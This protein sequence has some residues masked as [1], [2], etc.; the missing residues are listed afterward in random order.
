MKGKAM[1]AWAL[2]LGDEGVTGE[3]LQAAVVASLKTNKFMP[4]PA[5]ILKIVWGARGALQAVI[6]DP[7]LSGDQSSAP[8][9]GSRKL[10]E[11]KGLP[12]RELVMD[13]GPKALPS[14]KERERVIAR[15]DKAVKKLGGKN[16]MP[17]SRVRAR[18]ET[19]PDPKHLAKVAAQV[20]ELAGS[21][22]EEA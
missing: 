20:K 5:D 13:D 18:K 7:V 2:I 16:R 11:A 3:E 17:D 21:E 22:A 6:L 12:Y 1:R 4:T 8:R 10:C 14:P 15:L 9:V 19:A